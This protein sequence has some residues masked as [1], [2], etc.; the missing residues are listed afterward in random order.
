MNRLGVVLNDVGFE[1]AFDVLLERLVRPLAAVLF[2]DE[3]GDSLDHHHAFAVRYDNKESGLDMHTD[4][5]EVTLNVSLVANYAGSGSLRF[6]GMEKTTSYRTFLGDCAHTPGVA[7][8]HAGGRRH[9]A[10]SIE[11][12]ERVNMIVWCRSREYRD[13]LAEDT[14]NEEEEDADER[15]RIPDERCLSRTHDADY[16]EFLGASKRG[17][18]SRGEEVGSAQH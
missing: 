12:G 13:H 3:G 16:V 5:S 8:L 17:N 11:E 18:K 4:D 7:V 1:G 6:C 2:A 10:N 15:R 14:T 9:G